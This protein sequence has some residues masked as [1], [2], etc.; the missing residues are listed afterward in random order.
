MLLII[1]YAKCCL[2]QHFSAIH[3]NS[4]SMHSKPAMWA[5]QAC[6]AHK[7]ISACTCELRHALVAT[8]ESAVQSILLQRH[9]FHGLHFPQ[10]GTHG[11]RWHALALPDS[12]HTHTRRS[13]TLQPDSAVFQSSHGAHGGANSLI[14]AL[15]LRKTCLRPSV[16]APTCIDR[17]ALCR[18]VRKCADVRC[19]AYGR[20]HVCFPSATGPPRTRACRRCRGG[21]GM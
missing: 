19:R 3:K 20:R 7:A 18:R 10:T 12:L 11:L 6:S 4:K 17:K 5:T 16:K 14:R 13:T 21:F 2:C 1:I 8:K 9:A 15:E